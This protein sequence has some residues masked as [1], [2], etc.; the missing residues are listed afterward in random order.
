MSLQILLGNALY[1]RKTVIGSEYVDFAD[2]S[3]LALGVQLRDEK[4]LN[5]LSSHF[6]LPTLVEVV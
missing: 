4:E 3:Y 1:W 6:E 2:E 5:R